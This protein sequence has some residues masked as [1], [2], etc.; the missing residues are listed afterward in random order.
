MK[1]KSLYLDKS[2]FEIIYDTLFPNGT[3]SDKIDLKKRT[4]IA[5]AG[6]PCSGK[7]TVSR[8]IEKRYGGVR[9]NLDDVMRII[10]EKNLVETIEQNEEMKNLFIYTFLK[11]SF[12]KNKLII[13]DKSMDREYERFF[14]VCK[15]NEWDYLIVQ[16]KLKKQEAIRRIEKRNSDNLSNWIPRIDKWFNE[17]EEFKKNVKA[18]I[19]MD[20]TKS[21]FEVL[22]DNLD[23]RF[24]ILK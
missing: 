7:S 9:I 18:D 3:N 4:V 8:K 1:N 20:G 6:V 21:N 11:N 23:K 15:E 16:L 12:L 10:T 2:K 22:F 19:L 14:K 5:F 17:H 13:L 24:S